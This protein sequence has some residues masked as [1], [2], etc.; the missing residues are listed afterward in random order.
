MKTLLATVGLLRAGCR[1][2][3]HPLGNFTTNRYAALVVEPRAV[4]V[5][6]ALDLAELPTYRE[7]PQVDANGDGTP[8]PAE[9]DAYAARQAAAIASGLDLG[10]RRHAA[11]ARRRSTTALEISPGAG[12]LSTLRLDVTY[13]RAAAAARGR[14]GVRR[15]Q[16]RRPSGLAGGGGRAVGRREADAGPASRIAT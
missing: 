1:R 6:Y 7:L 13:R 5:V 12:G 14:S 9:R 3:A 11:R 4:R 16:L 2:R 8:D 15:S 10:A